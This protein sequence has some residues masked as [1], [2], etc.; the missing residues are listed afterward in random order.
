M[1]EYCEKVSYDHSTDNGAYIEYEPNFDCQLWIASVDGKYE[2]ISYKHGSLGNISH[3]PWCGC[4][5]GK[6]PAALVE[7]DKRLIALAS[8][9]SDELSDVC[10]IIEVCDSLEEF[11]D[12]MKYD[13]DALHGHEVMYYTVIEATPIAK[14]RHVAKFERIS[15]E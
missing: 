1:C 7:E 9:Y 15:D 8:S 2:L 3:C 10:E 6:E 11:E 4:K 13:F 14:Y 5:L 12:S